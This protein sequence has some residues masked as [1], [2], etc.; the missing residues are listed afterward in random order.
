[1]GRPSQLDD[2]GWVTASQDM[3]SVYQDIERIAEQF[4]G[5]SGKPMAALENALT[6]IN[7]EFGFDPHRDRSMR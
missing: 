3:E 5:D 4:E 1:M 2:I 6:I 7:N